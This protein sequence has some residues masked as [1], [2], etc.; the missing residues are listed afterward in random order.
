[1]EEDKNAQKE[2]LRN[3]EKRVARL[4]ENLLDITPRRRDVNWAKEL[5]R[6][7]GFVI[8]GIIVLC[9]LLFLFIIFFAPTLFPK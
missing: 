1:M 2:E 4:E 6:L 5:M 8:I 7:C 3:L 9:A